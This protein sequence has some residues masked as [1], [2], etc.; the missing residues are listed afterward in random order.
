[1]KYVLFFCC[2]V[3]L[4]SCGECDNSKYYQ[5]KAVNPAADKPSMSIYEADGLGPCNSWQ[6]TEVVM[7][8][9]ST[10]RFKLSEIVSREVISQYKSRGT[11]K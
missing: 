5:I 1:M 3:V 7:F 8:T 2:L 9:D 4:W 10:A 6:K 11:T